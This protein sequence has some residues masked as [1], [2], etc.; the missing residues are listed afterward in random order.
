M[1]VLIYAYGTRGDVQPSVALGHALV[2]AGHQAVLAAP[3]RYAD[4]AA[5]Y[6]LEFVPRDEQW[7]SLMTDNPDVR[8]LYHG[9]QKKRTERQ[10]EIFEWYKA[11]VLRLV[12]VLLED[13]WNA[14][15]G[16][17]DVIVYQDTWF[18]H[19]N[20]VAEALG[21][22]SVLA[23]QYPQSVPSWEYPSM[24]VPPGKKLPRVL[25]RL[26]HWPM[27]FMVSE[28]KRIDAWRTELLGLAPRKRRFDRLTLP[29]G[30][31]TQVL[32]SFSRHV[33]EPAPSWG[34]HIHTTGF[35]FLPAADY[36]PPAALVDFLAAGEAPV[37][38]GFGSIVGKDPAETGRVVL[39]AI[40]DTRAVIGTGWGGLE[41]TDVPDN[42][43][44]IDQAPYDWL[45]P[46][47]RAVVHAGGTG[48]INY[49][50]AAGLPQVA[51]VFHHEQM[52]WSKN[53]HAL[54]AAPAPLWM[55]TLESG[56]LREAIQAACTDPSMTA[57]ARRA[58]AGMRTEDGTANAVAVLEKI[59]GK[60]AAPVS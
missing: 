57:A 17:A 47:V 11:E 18:T 13:Q 22:P 52:M 46:Q 48:T 10:K 26:S 42:V 2:Q 43:H 25:N 3:A 7:L 59:H 19:A 60:V 23:V 51:C 31:P 4:F 44:V 40:G 12:P 29:D 24:L 35:W 9:D 32:Q 41:L 55:D 1:K 14:A 28:K 5:E 50:L 6:G 58:G 15:A 16:G 56:A 34:P 49:A 39:E 45:F 30:A 33:V 21:I 8:E 20:H 38:V 53:L 36:T 54:G 27:R 37:F